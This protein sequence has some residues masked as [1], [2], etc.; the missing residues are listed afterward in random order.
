MVERMCDRALAPLKR[1][2]G[3][4][5]IAGLIAGASVAAPAMAQTPD[6]DKAAETLKT[7]RD[8]QAAR[9][10]DMLTM[11]TLAASKN[12]AISVGSIEATADGNAVRVKNIVI[13][14]RQAMTVQMIPLAI[15]QDLDKRHAISRHFRI[16]LYS[17]VVEGTL[18][19]MV[20]PIIQAMGVKSFAGRLALEFKF[21]EPNSALDIKGLSFEWEGVARIGF[22]LRLVNVPP[23]NDMILLGVQ[24]RIEPRLGEIRLKSASLTLRNR[25]LNKVLETMAKMFAPGAGGKSALVAQL[26]QMKAQAQIDLQ[27]RIVDALMPAA[28][29]PAIVTIAISSAEGV[30]LIALERISNPMQLEQMFEIKIEGRPVAPDEAMPATLPAEVRETVVDKDAKDPPAHACDAVGALPIDPDK[31]GPGVADDK[32]DVPQVLADCVRATIE[33]PAAAR[34][35]LQLGRAL[36]MAGH[37]PMANAELKMAV[38]LGS[39]TAKKYLTARPAK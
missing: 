1:A 23:V 6:N 19:P 17:D 28:Q 2:A 12:V 30:P 10:R 38:D 8:N 31:K 4:A 3:A 34:F 15:I 13:A 24:D 35:H 25:S 32:L 39:E 14:D 26:E 22:N 18:P 27:R 21:D 11:I 16:V 33:Y 9:V 29:G 5:A 7:M 37:K 20:G 36:W